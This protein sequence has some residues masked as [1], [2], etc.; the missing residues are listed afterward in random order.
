MYK[1]QSYIQNIFYL[2][3][4]DLDIFRFLPYNVIPDSPTESNHKN[5]NSKFIL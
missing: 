3:D 5:I 2:L 4:L 1:W